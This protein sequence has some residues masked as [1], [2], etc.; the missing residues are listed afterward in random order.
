MLIAVWIGGDLGQVLT[1]AVVA[2]PI[3]TDFG[4]P[5]VANLREAAFSAE[6]CLLECHLLR[7]DLL[8]P[9]LR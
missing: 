3:R 2:S 9:K 7:P 4:L 8:R 1:L 5:G 6:V